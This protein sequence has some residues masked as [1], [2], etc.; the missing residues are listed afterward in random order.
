[1]KNKILSLD[2]A[3]RAYKKRP[4]KPKAKTGKKGLAESERALQLAQLDQEPF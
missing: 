2:D 1:M 3:I 4:Q